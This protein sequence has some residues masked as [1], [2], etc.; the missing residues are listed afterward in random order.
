MGVNCDAC[1]D[2]Q[3]T[4]FRDRNTRP[5]YNIPVKF[6]PP[7]RKLPELKVTTVILSYVG[8]EEDLNHMLQ[9]L[10]RN[11]RNFY[12]NWHQFLRRAVTSYEPWIKDVVEFG[13]EKYQAD[14][15]FPKE[16]Q[17]LNFPKDTIIR[18][19][20]IRYKTSSAKGQSQFGLGGI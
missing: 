19:S 2:Q 11:C 8:Y 1:S 10:S 17:L 16:D 14:C 4:D 18:L 13:D 6:K 20:E 9:I 7:F 12:Q 3:T 5:K 15:V